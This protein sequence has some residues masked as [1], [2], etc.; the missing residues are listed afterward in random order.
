MGQLTLCPFFKPPKQCTIDMAELVADYV[1]QLCLSEY[2]NCDKYKNVEK[3]E[4][5]NEVYSAVMVAPCDEYSP[6]PYFKKLLINDMCV[7]KCTVTD[8]YLTLFRIKKCVELYKLCP[9]RRVVEA[10]G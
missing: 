9:F 3:V 6:C 4:N 7:Y 1:K 8:Q 10:R 2:A 5:S